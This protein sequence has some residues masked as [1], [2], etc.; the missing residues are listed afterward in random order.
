MA[1]VERT[2]VR[3]ADNSPR[4]TPQIGVFEQDD[5]GMFRFRR[6]LLKVG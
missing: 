5:M 4:L 2:K 3:D 6:G 1:E